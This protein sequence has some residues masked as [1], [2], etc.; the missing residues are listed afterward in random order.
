MWHSY[1]V[2]D[3]EFRL[4]QPPPEEWGMVGAPRH[5]SAALPLHIVIVVIFGILALSAIGGGT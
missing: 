2:G 4:V 1:T 3:D 5:Q